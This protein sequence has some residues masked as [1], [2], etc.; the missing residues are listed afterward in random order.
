MP[1]VSGKSLVDTIVNCLSTAHKRFPIFCGVTN[2][3][4]SESRVCI[5]DMSEAF[6]R[7]TTP[8]DDWT[9]SVYFAV[10]YRLL[11]EDLF[12]NKKLSGKEIQD[13]MAELGLTDALVKHHMDYLE[14]QDQLMKLFW[15]DEV[16]RLGRVHGALEIL[17][18]MAFEGRK[19]RVGMMVGS[20]IAQH[21]PPQMVKLATS[22][23][24]FGVN[25]SSQMATA[26]GDIFSLSEDECKAITAITKPNAE[27]GA[28]VF[29]VHRVDTGSQNMKLHFQL[30]AIKRWAYATEAEERTL[31]GILY[32]EG[33][34]TG[35]ARKMLASKV[36]NVKQLIKTKQQALGAELS[37]QE[38]IRQI[39]D[40]LLRMDK[41][42]V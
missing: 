1:E 37:E 23:F 20:Q 14:E 10:V 31:R 38:A 36:G 19:Y 21:L 26:L 29:V 40:Q 4:I 17:D 15:A 32:K 11:S 16:H 3:D 28:E 25:Q 33:S 7:G 13:R 2:T 22:A 18:S 41:Q 27:K 34:S 8:F 5:F 9:R 35:W 24:I 39:A 30:G 6:G 42:D 12:V